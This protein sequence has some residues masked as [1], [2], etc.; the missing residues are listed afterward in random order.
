MVVTLCGLIAV[1]LLFGFARIVYELRGGKFFARGW[2]G[3]V[4]AARDQNPKLYWM[5][6]VLEIFVAL[7]VTYVFVTNL[8]RVFGKG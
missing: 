8:F 2:K 6:M 1:S 3:K 5:Y 4:Y 7:F